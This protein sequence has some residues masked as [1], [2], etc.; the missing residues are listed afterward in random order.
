MRDTFRV[1]PRLFIYATHYTLD[2]NHWVSH[3]CWKVCESGKVCVSCFM[4][5]YFILPECSGPAGSEMLQL[6]PALS[7]SPSRSLCKLSELLI[8]HNAADT[9]P[10]K[11]TSAPLCLSHRCDGK[12]IVQSRQ[13]VFTS[14][15]KYGLHISVRCLSQGCVLTV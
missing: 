4:V 11:P 2:H 5:V 3:H 10:N 8:S 12:F 9:F 6:L 13:M 7:L 1:H 14:S 15:L